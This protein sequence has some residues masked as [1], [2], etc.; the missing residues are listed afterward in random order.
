MK[1]DSLLVTHPNLCFAILLLIFNAAVIA[2]Y[3]VGRSES[4]TPVLASISLKGDGK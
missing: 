2:A 3:F 1:P 4:K